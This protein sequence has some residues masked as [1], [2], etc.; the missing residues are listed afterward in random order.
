MQKRKPKMLI[1]RLK[2]CGIS[3]IFVNTDVEFALD[4]LK[5]RVDIK[6]KG[7]EF[8]SLTALNCLLSCSAAYV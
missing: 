8:Q 7:G 3:T 2:M 4:I 1:K 5:S 6:L